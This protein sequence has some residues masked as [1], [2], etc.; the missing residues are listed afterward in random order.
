MVESD[1]NS[2]H[3]KLNSD[4]RGRVTLGSEYAD[5]KVTVAVLE[6]VE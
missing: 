5:K 3:E 2:V 1:T 4:S 6:V